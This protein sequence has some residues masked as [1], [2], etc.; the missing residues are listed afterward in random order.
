MELAAP[1]PQVGGVRRRA[2]PVLELVEQHRRVGARLDEEDPRLPERGEV[3]AGR[4]RRLGQWSTDT[5]SAAR[6]SRAGCPIQSKVAERACRA[7]PDRDRLP[8]RFLT[9]NLTP[10]VAVGAQMASAPLFAGADAD[11]LVHR[12]DPDLAVA[13]LA[14]PGRR[15][16]SVVDRPRPTSP[17]EHHHLH[18][19]LRDEVDGVLRAAVGLGVTALAAEPHHGGHGEAGHLHGL[20]RLADEVHGEGLDD[21]GD[22]AEQVRFLRTDDRRDPPFRPGQPSDDANLYVGAH[23]TTDG[24]TT[25]AGRVVA[26]SVG[27]EP[28]VTRKPQRFSR[29]SHSSALAALRLS[30]DIGGPA[31]LFT[32]MPA[33][34]GGEEPVEERGRRLARTPGTTVRTSWFRRG[35]TQR[36]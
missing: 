34:A 30:H 4:A 12:G 15:P 26:E 29:P 13:D 25:T 27:F 36:L 35:S 9:S 21:G 23:G 17:S 1:G 33:P 2:H 11:H 18:L 31:R 19:H 14:G 3:V 32:G 8:D 24:P 10:P 16:R 20:Q 22:E 28:T 7:L 5:P 6:V